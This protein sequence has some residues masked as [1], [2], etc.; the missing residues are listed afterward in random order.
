L[1][2]YLLS[3]VLAS[4]APSRVVVVSSA[5]S[6]IPEMLGPAS[7]L[8]FSAKSDVDEGS[9]QAYGPWTAYGRSKLAN[10]LFAQE[11][12][13]R[14]GNES[15]VYVNALH[16]GGIRTNLARHIPV[17]GGE[18]LA[19][20]FTL[21]AGP[22]LMS[23]EQ[24]AVTQLFVATSPEVEQRAITGAYFH[25]QAREV[26]PTV[27]ATAANREALWTLSMQLTASFRAG[28]TPQSVKW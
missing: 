5:A 27:L 11:L 3:D 1:L 21:V 10:V 12:A 16:P 18:R 22:L 14:F 24:G 25:P 2:A 20:L 7:A 23:P 19:L 15:G 13:S 4:S 8:N 28:F 17:T 6:F 9:A 26:P